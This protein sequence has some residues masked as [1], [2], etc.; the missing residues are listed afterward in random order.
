MQLLSFSL[1]SDW[2]CYQI[3][4][5]KNVPLALLLTV[6]LSVSISYFHPIS[7][8]AHAQSCLSNAQARQAVRS[9]E[10]RPLAQIRRQALRNGGRIVNAQ[11]CRSGRG[12]VYVISVLQPNGQVANLTVPAR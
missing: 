9:G 1:R 8:A 10:A 4:M 11:L 2:R 12:L 3:L 5:I 7:S 6:A